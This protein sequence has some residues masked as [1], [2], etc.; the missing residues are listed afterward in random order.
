MNVEIQELPLINVA[1]VRH[2]GKFKG[3]DSVFA[4]AFETLCGW[5]G[6]KGL[7]NN[8]T[9]FLAVYYDD[10][11]VTAEDKMRVDICLSVPE[12]TETPEGIGQLSLPAGKY[13]IARIEAKNTADFEAGWNELYRQWL[14]QSGYE[15]NNR[16]CL[17]IYRNDPKKDQSGKYITDI[18]V[19]LK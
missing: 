16:P 15:F 9:L 12:G 2:I 4:K 6:P 5:A 13:A 19:P 18:C 17:E 1:Y 11:Q 3:D 8:Q 10:P 7:I 14:P